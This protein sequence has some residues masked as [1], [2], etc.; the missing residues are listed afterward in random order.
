[1]PNGEI[2]K[3][4]ETNAMVHANALLILRHVC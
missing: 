4:A 1:M 2:T 3:T